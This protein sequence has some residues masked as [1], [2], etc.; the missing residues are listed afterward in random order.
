M[1]RFYIPSGTSLMR[2]PYVLCLLGRVYLQTVKEAN[3]EK[4]KNTR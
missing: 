2:A 3:R 4:Y 1:R